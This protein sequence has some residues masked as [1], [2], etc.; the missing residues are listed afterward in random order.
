MEM[1]V[2]VE[3]HVDGIKEGRGEDE[4]GDGERMTQIEVER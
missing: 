1:D 2:E 3:T 4:E